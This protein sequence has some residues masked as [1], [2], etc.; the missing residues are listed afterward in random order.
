MSKTLSIYRDDNYVLNDAFDQIVM[1]IHINKKN[2]GYKTYTLCGSEPGCGNTT[3]AINLAAS[4]AASGYKTVLVDGDMRKKNEYKRLN[5]SATVGFS[6]Y[7]MNKADLSSVIY[8]TDTEG[9]SYVPCGKLIDNPVRLLCSDKAEEFREKLKE[10]FDFVIYDMP[11]VNVSSDANIA[12][13]SSDATI[14]TVA[15]GDTTKKG[16]AESAN[17]LAAA[18]ANIIGTIIN[19]ADRDEYRRYNKDF[20]Y[21]EKEKFVKK[22]FYKTAGKA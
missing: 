22:K 1:N 15:I 20:D 9:L 7:L 11:A 12:A 2:N 16:L 13:L 4:I 5:E 19:K 18:G 3:V 6:D 17:T 8:N 14:I 21:F 10:E